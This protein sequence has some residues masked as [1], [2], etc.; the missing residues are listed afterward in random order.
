[1]E[2]FKYQLWGKFFKRFRRETPLRDD[3][4]EQLWNQIERI[5]GYQ[6]YEE[7]TNNAKSETGPR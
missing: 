4:D 5:L 3:L 6:L 2:K 7:G 1:M